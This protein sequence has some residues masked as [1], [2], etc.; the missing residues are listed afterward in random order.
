[1]SPASANLLRDEEVPGG[2]DRRLRM[3][4]IGCGAVAEWCHLPAAKRVRQIEVVSV[5]DTNLERAERL[6]RRF[7]VSHWGADLGQLPGGID[8]AVVAVPNRHHGAV[9]GECLRRGIPI[10]LEKPL[11]ATVE[12]AQAIA[13]LSERTGVLLQIGHVYRFCRGAQLVKR[14]LEE[15]WLGTVRRIS[16]EWG[17]VFDWPVASGFIWDK[18]QAGGGVL[19]DAGPHVLDLLFWWMGEPLAFEYWDDARGGV[20]AECAISLTWRGA[21]G[22]IAGQVVMSRLRGLSNSVRIV[23]ERFS[24]EYGINDRRGEIRLW[25]TR[26]APGGLV[27]V[28]DRS[29]TPM[30]SW[31]EVFADQLRAFVRA[32]GDGGP[33]PVSAAEGLRAVKWVEACYR[34]R[35]PLEYP[36]L[37][38]NPVPASVDG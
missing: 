5:V 24:L 12:E 4:L 31:E 1:M 33:A 20:E 25:P 21:G 28:P 37:D 14:C 36:W 11:A 23:A 8:G 2:R 19:I 17:S 6:A 27:L 3:A 38:S 16:V 18:E 35:R 7:G 30:Q 13:A 29:V 22:L 9:A 26:D 32:V 10:L 34:A 15:G